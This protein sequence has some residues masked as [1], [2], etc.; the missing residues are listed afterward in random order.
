MGKVINMRQKK[1][2][3][4]HLTDKLHL[5]GNRLHSQNEHEYCA[6]CKKEFE[7]D[8]KV[9]PYTMDGYLVLLCSEQCIKE[10]GEK[11]SRGENL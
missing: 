4:Q 10:L 6:N 11:Y 9:Y 1:A 5:E 3:I 2:K 7:E 8:D